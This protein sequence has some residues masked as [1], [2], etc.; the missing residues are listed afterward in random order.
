[1]CDTKINRRNILKAIKGGDVTGCN[2]EHCAKSVVRCLGADSTSWRKALPILN[3][4]WKAGEIE[5][6]D[7]QLRV[8]PLLEQQE[9]KR[10]ASDEQKRRKAARNRQAAHRFGGVRG[11][12]VVAT[13]IVANGDPASTCWHI[14]TEG[15]FSVTP[16]IRPAG[17]W[18]DVV[19][20]LAELEAAQRADDALGCMVQPEDPDVLCYGTCD[21]LPVERVVGKIA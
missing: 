3:A 11:L 17:G 4:L 2:I 8:I 9:N 1:M 5:L 10:R 12:P 14:A 21:D 20:E 15:E 13:N 16:P 18:V 19:D 6:R 7:A